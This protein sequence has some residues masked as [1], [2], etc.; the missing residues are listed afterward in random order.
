MNYWT[1]GLSAFQKIGDAEISILYALAKH[2]AFQGPD[3]SKPRFREMRYPPS[4]FRGTMRMCNT[5]NNAEFE[6]GYRI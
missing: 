6:Q 2:M 5:Y 1:S 3:T 4:H